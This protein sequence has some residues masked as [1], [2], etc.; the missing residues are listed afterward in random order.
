MDTTIASSKYDP[1]RLLNT[2]MERL[3]LPSDKELSQRLNIST[4]VLRKIRTGELT[5]SA[6]MLLWMAECAQTT[7]EELRSIL[8]DRRR[9]LRLS[10]VI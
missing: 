6:S 5:I 4:K 2:L 9:K 1:N 3:G 10:Y 7:I 8:G